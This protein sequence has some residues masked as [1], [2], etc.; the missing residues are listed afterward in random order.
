MSKE[1]PFD[2]WAFVEKNLD[3]DHWYIRLTG[4]KY[5]GVVYHYDTIRLNEETESINFDYDVIDYLDE[6][7]HGDP[8]FNVAL[9]DILKVILDDAMQA[10]D[11]VLGDKNERRVDNT[12]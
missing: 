3:Q 2:T 6:D 12:S 5:H 8:E 1:K 11:Y 9:G 10:G 7:P 4:G